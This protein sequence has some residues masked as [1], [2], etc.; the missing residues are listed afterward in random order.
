MT[1]HRSRP[2]PEPIAHTPELAILGAL[3]ELLDLARRTL[4]AAHPGLGDTDV[5]YWA[6]DRDALSEAARGLIARSA[7]L[8][9]AIRT[10]EAAAKELRAPSDDGSD[11]PF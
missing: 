6:G 8:Q 11:L 10:Y 3:D 7:T 1:R 2:T 5:P 4:L 9:R